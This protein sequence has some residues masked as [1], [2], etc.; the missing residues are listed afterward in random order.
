MITKGLS[1]NLWPS[2]TICQT[3]FQEKACPHTLPLQDRLLA[4]QTLGRGNS[5]NSHKQKY[6]CTQ[7][8]LCTAILVDLID[9]SG[10]ILQYV[11]QIHISTHKLNS[12]SARGLSVKSICGLRSQF[13]QHRFRKK[14]FPNTLPLQDCLLAGKT[15]RR[16]NLQKLQ[17]HIINLQFRANCTTAL[18][19]YLSQSSPPSRRQR[20]P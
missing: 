12:A 2:I 14:A 8:A 4:G 3:S 10:C 18:H 20:S 13:V 1:A 11:I 19:R 6:S 16:S 17:L 5:Q 7:S 9:P 15:L